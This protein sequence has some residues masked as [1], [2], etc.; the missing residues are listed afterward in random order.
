M[1][2][3]IIGSIRGEVDGVTCRISWLMVHPSFRGLDLEEPLV[4]SIENFFQNAIRFEAIVY[5]KSQNIIA[6]QKLGYQISKKTELSNKMAMV[7]LEKH[8]YD[9]NLR[10]SPS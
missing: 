8:K 4:T 6:Y 9:R 1:D 3:K 5:D 10:P 7:Y 2:D